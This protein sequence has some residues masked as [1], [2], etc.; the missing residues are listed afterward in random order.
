MTTKN[1]DFIKSKLK[2]SNLIILSLGG[3]IS[4]ILGVKLTISGIENYVIFF[5]SIPF[6]LLGLVS[7]YSF[8]NFDILYITKDKLIFKSIFGFNK[9]TINLSQILSFNEIKKENAKYK[10]EIGHMK[11]KE[12][13]LF[14]ENFKYKISSTSYRNYTELKRNLTRGIYRDLKSE[15]E[16]K[17][18]NNL[19]FGIGFLIFGILVCIWFGINSQNFNELLFTG[20]VSSLFIIYGIYLIRKNKKTNR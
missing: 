14:G 12:L 8:L 9:R 18:K 11:W 6:L 2:Y 5:V 10:H 20:I 19:Y 7:T 17:R 13:T 16:W 4:T 15:A 3:I 1:N